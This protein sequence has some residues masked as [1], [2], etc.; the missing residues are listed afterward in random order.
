MIQPLNILPK[1]PT[2]ALI[3][4]T[5]YIKNEPSMDGNMGEKIDKDESSNRSLFAYNPW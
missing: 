3:M 1:I 5:Y 2:N 4:E